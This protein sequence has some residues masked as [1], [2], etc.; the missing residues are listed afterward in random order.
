MIEWLNKSK[1]SFYIYSDFKFLII[2]WHYFKI[3]IELSFS[4]SNET[5]CFKAK[6]IDFSAD[7]VHKL[8]INN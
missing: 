5:I 8:T 3:C 4:L 1:R 6:A 2:S 7:Y